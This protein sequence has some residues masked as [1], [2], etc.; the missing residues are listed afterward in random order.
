M[1]GTS[2]SAP[3]FAGMVTILNAVRVANNQPLLGWLNPLFYQ[4]AQDMPF[5]FNDITVGNNR[6]G[7]YGNVP[8]MPTCCDQAYEAVPGI[9]TIYIISIVA[10]GMQSLFYFNASITMLT[11][12]SCA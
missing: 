10:F 1:L 12:F 2:A 11:L 9:Y 7:A 4:I 8:P 5:A 6:C 3:I